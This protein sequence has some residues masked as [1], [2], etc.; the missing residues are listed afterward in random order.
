MANNDQLEKNS[1]WAKRLNWVLRFKDNHNI[2]LQLT[3]EVIPPLLKP[4]VPNYNRRHFIKDSRESFILQS[5]KGNH[6][7]ISEMVKNSG[8]KVSVALILPT[9]SHPPLL[10]HFTDENQSQKR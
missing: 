8:S 1:V 7:P 4:K 9:P 10:Y 6:I 3:K 5:S 2:R